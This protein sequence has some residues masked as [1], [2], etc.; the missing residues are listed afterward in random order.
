MWKWI[1][2]AWR[3]NTQS[4]RGVARRSAVG[5]ETGRESIIV[6]CL[7]TT[8]SP[9]RRRT[10]ASLER[11]TRLPRACHSR[12]SQYAGGSC[13]ASTPSAR[14]RFHL[15][16]LLACLTTT[17][18]A[19][20]KFTAPAAGASFAAGVAFTITWTDDGKTPTID[21][22]KT[23]TLDVMYGGDTVGTSVCLFLSRPRVRALA[24]AACR[25]Y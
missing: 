15:L 3:G 12:A 16:P 4:F 20:V 6:V 13:V 21:Q 14:M 5:G 18:L 8:K 1:S 9:S 17:A 25:T 2:L 19:N 24:D 7:S 22:F 11:L 23:Y 10:Q